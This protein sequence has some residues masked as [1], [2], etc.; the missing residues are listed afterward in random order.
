ME[1]LVDSLVAVLV[2]LRLDGSDRFRSHHSSFVADL[3]AVD[4]VVVEGVL[5]VVL[6]GVELAVVVLIGCIE[7]ECRT[8]HLDHESGSW[9]YRHIHPV[10]RLRLDPL[11]GTYIHH[12]LLV[13]AVV[14]H[15]HMEAHHTDRIL[16]YPV[17]LAS[18]VVHRHTA[19]VVPV[20]V[21]RYNRRHLLDAFL[22]DDDSTVVGV[23]VADGAV[24]DGVVEGCGDT[25]SA[26]SADDVAA[27]DGGDY[28]CCGGAKRGLD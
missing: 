1:G 15:H 18:A 6:V 13:V 22:L 23:L 21:G 27:A 8:A 25:P 14:V 4:L 7:T 17:V 3:A 20:L 5:V 10:V 16:P 26:G 24:V 2:E 19:P 9:H 11:V 12:L 28:Y